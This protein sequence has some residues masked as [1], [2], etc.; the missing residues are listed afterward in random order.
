MRAPFAPADLRNLREVAFGVSVDAI[1]AHVDELRAAGFVDVEAEDQSA[2]WA[3]FTAARLAA[4]RAGHAGY[5]R[6]HG[7]AAYAAQELFYAVIA[8]L[9]ACGSLG[10]VRLV[11]RL[12]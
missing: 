10:G 2:D 7:E 11:A 5:A 12:G 1:E 9:F 6:V 4:W 3:P 8:G